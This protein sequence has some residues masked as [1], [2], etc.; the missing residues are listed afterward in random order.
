MAALTEN[1]TIK[2]SEYIRL[3]NCE[4]GIDSI[5]SNVDKVKKHYLLKLGLLQKYIENK[6]PSFLI[7]DYV[8]QNQIIEMCAIAEFLLSC[9]VISMDEFEKLSHIMEESGV[10]DNV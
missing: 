4:T 2:L 8:Y 7:S 3:K 10:H 1:I 9:N 6:E 5:H